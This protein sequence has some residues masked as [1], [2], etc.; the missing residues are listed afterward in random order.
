M[1]KAHHNVVAALNLADHNLHEE[2]NP[3]D[4]AALAHWT[5]GHRPDL[6]PNLLAPGKPNLKEEGCN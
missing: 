6:D 4:Q 1:M 5:Y 2:S 3:V